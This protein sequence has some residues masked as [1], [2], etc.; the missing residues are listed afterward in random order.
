MTPNEH[1][2]LVQRILMVPAKVRSQGWN[3]LAGRI[4][5]I[6]RGYTTSRWPA[7]LLKSVCYSLARLAILPIGDYRRNVGS[8]LYVYYDLDLYPISYDIGYFLIWADLERQK[9]KLDHLYVVLLPIADEGS[10]V[11]PQGYDKVVDRHSRHWRFWHIVAPL[12]DLL[13]SITGVSI[14]GS[15][16]H[17]EIFR[18]VARHNHPVAGSPLR[19]PPSLSQIYRCIIAE[20]RL[21]TAHEGLQARPQACRYIR[22]WADHH[23]TG[24]KLVVITLRR[25]GVDPERNSN[26][27]A[28]GAFARA[29]P[30]ELLPV[31]VPDT[32]H[33]LEHMP[34]ELDGLT[35][36]QPAAW[37]IELRMAL[38]ESAYLNLVVNSGPSTLCV[39]SRKCRYV[40]FK[41]AVSNVH[42][43]SHS[44]LAEYGFVPGET[45][46]FCARFQKWVW[47][48]D[49]LEII[50]REFEAMRGKIESAER[51]A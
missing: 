21:Q 29:L 49:D 48:P 25:Y 51:A 30:P 20:L 24:R 16:F 28:W 19:P 9:R 41:I 31:I 40:M 34:A 44:V 47:Q 46:G 5:E 32:D 4:G 3:W 38:Y 33:A 15:R 2:S 50:Q 8:T 45:P 14:A 1:P 18:A 10:R 17:A 11:F 35:V 27:A 39:L 36:F 42:L 22:Q 23:A 13:P 37:N 43:A 26:V 12:A 6:A 7:W